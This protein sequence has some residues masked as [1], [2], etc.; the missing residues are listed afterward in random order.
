MKWSDLNRGTDVAVKEIN[1]PRKKRSSTIS[2]SRLSW[3]QKARINTGPTDESTENCDL[4]NGQDKEITL[5][6]ARD[7][8]PLGQVSWMKRLSE[9]GIPLDAKQ[10]ISYSEDF[11]ARSIM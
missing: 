3:H 1:L 10:D 4:D 6:S 7:S 9:I 11:V 8:G 2:W 5:S